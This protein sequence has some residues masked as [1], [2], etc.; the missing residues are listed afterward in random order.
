M[1]YYNIIFLAL[2]SLLFISISNAKAIEKPNKKE[3]N[4]YA[5]HSIH[6]K[7]YPKVK[8]PFKYYLDDEEDTD[9]LIRRTSFGLVKG[10]TQTTNDK[11]VSIWYGIPYGA[12]PVGELRWAAPKNPKP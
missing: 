4:D 2:F 6:H 11:V 8:N 10:T 5:N 3:L 1:R 12:A 7:K 9:S